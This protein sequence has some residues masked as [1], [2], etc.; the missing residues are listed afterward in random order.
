MVKVQPSAVSGS[1]VAE[2]IH[3]LECLQ[4]TAGGF[5]WRCYTVQLKITRN[6][7]VLSWAQFGG[8]STTSTVLQSAAGGTLSCG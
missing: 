2:V 5:T 6:V 7:S 4:A 1:I 3:R 8:K